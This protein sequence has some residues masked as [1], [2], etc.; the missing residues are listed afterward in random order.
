MPQHSR[1]YADTR[2]PVTTS[3]KQQPSPANCP[4]TVDCLKTATPHCRQFPQGSQHEPTA[5]GSRTQI[6]KGHPHLHRGGGKQGLLARDRCS[7]VSF[8]SY[9]PQGRVKFKP[10]PARCSAP[11]GFGTGQRAAISRQ[12]P[13]VRLATYAQRKV[14]NLRSKVHA[15]ER[16]YIRSHI[17]SD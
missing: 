17:G 2:K 6:N 15:L 14:D 10:A 9:P 16:S 5:S 1:R 13:A 7:R 4:K 8:P 12:E 3:P 11:D